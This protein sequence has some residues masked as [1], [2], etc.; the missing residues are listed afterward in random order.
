MEKLNKETP[1][2][3]VN[4]T[5]QAI[6]KVVGDEVTSSYGVG[7]IVSGGKDKGKILSEDE[8]YKGIIISK[9]RESYVVDIHIYVLFPLKITEIVN[10]VQKK[11]RYALQKV[12]SINFK[13]VNIYVEGLLID[14][15]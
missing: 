9:D 15:H 14:R 4:I 3:R 5:K 10:E 13:S 1:Y 6:S 7:G 11:V 8:Y 2:G 12:F